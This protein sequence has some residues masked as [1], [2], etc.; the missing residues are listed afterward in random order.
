[1]QTRSDRSDAQFALKAC[2]SGACAASFGASVLTAALLFFDTGSFRSLML[3]DANGDAWREVPIFIL[4][5]GLIGFV[6]GPA[7]A[8]ARR[9]G[10]DD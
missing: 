2:L 7:I 5:M 1:M 9:R 8:G 10:P 4:S 6:T 3:N